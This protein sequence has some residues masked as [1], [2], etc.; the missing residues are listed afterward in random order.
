MNRR[1]YRFPTPDMFARPRDLAERISV[2]PPPRTFTLPI[3]AARAKA[4]EILEQFP[5]SGYMAIVENWRQLPDG[6]IE[7]TMR[8]LPAAE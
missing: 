7:F 1:Y 6:R 8:H 2:T 5:K 3:E 4:R